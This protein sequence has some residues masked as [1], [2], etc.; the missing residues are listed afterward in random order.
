MHDII[1]EIKVENTYASHTHNRHTYTP[2]HQIVYEIYAERFHVNEI[3]IKEQQKMESI[4]CVS[5]WKNGMY[6]K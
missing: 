1:F 2:T 6:L 5:F 3:F 4:I